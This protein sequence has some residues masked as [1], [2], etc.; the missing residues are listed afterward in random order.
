MTFCPDIKKIS[1]AQFWQN[2]F[3]ILKKKSIMKILRYMLFQLRKYGVKILE[4]DGVV[5]GSVQQV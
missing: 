5:S 1:Y 2:I 4:E 3:K